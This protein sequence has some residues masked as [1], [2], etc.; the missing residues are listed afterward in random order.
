MN[1]KQDI[2]VVSFQEYDIIWRSQI[3]VQLD[4]IE[5]LLVKFMEDTPDL[6]GSGEDDDEGEGWKIN[7][8]NRWNW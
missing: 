8:N 2:R 5:A 1:N 7:I 3:Q 4:R 6:D